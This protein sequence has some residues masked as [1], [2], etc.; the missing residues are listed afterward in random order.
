M[1]T[2]DLDNVRAQVALLQH[3]KKKEAELKELKDR[4]RAAVEDAM[5]DAEHGVLDGEPVIHWPHLKQ[6]RLDQ[7]AL[8]EKE[9][10]LVEEYT[11]THSIR[12]FEVL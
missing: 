11:T 2:K 5:G 9:P 8:K 10:E 6:R 7:K 4:A 3:C 1:T 12:R